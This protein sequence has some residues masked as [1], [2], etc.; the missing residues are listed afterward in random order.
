MEL[1]PRVTHESTA[2]PGVRYTV[3]TLNQIQRAKRDLEVFPHRAKIA[4]LM[5]EMGR[6]PEND[7]NFT[8]RARLD[9]E[10]GL[11]INQHMKPAYLRAGLVSI[12]GVTID[13]RE[14]SVADVI[15]YGDDALV[16]E[17]Y[18]ACAVASGITVEQ[19]KNL[20]SPGTSENPGQPGESNT[21]VDAAAV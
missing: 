1:K 16:D 11:L 4:E 3:R 19:Q 18:A 8:K 20:Q 21:T 14:A 17:I 5:A 6:I 9:M 7:E 13:G 12:E 10:I 2:V 15:D